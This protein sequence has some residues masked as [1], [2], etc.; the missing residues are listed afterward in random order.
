MSDTKID[1][2]AEIAT[3]VLVGEL[4]RRAEAKQMSV[5]ALIAEAGANWDQAKTDADDLA[6]LGHEEETA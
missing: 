4:R 1:K 5:G 2:L 6:K 3:D